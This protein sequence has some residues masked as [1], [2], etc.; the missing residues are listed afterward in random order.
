[1]NQLVILTVVQCI[2][3]E[4][5]LKNSFQTEFTTFKFALNFFHILLTVYHDLNFALAVIV[6]SQF[7][8]VEL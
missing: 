4:R 6:I 7:F 2:L 1:M 8:P 3:W 5:P